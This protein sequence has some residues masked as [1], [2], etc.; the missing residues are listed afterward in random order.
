LN[1][2]GSKL[3]DHLMMDLLVVLFTQEASPNPGL[4][5]NQKEAISSCL[6]VLEYRSGIREQEDL[7][8][9]ADI[10]TVFNKGSVTIKKDIL[11]IHR[12]VSYRVIWFV[13]LSKRG[14]MI[15]ERSWVFI[16]RLPFFRLTASIFKMIR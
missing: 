5:G 6:K 7:L 2:K 9:S 4:I 8:R 10:M 14:R 11:D 12:H 3:F 16:R 15:W 1:G 13:T